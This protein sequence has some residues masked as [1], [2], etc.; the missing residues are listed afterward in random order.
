MTTS[1]PSP[2]A[3]VETYRAVHGGGATAIVSVHLSGEISGTV[4]AARPAAREV[5][6]D[7]IDVEV[8]DSRSMGMGLGYA[9]IT[10]ARAARRR[11][12]RPRRWR[13]D[14][15]HRALRDGDLPV[16]RH[17]GVPAPRRPDRRRAGA[18]WGRRWRSSRCCTWWTA[19]W[20]RWNGCGPPRVR[21]AGWWRSRCR[22][23]VRTRW[24]SPC[25]TW[26]PR[27][28]RRTSRT[29]CGRRSRPSVSCTS[30]EVGAVVG[31]HVG[32]GMIAVV[33]APAR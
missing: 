22:R 8:V 24:T 2:Q 9:V 25:T 10:A 15:A 33:V 11:R 18:G 31:A 29:G 19:G 23:G 20:S 6:G 12:G 14:A 5:A 3:F 27:T 30:G 7:G 1:R 17:A 13:G 26:R 16:R 21:S 28:V 32:P 4:D